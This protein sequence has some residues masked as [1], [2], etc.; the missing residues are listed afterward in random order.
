M[1]QDIGKFLLTLVVWVIC[2][3]VAVFPMFNE[4]IS[5]GAVMVIVIALIA[6]V[7]ATSVLWGDGDETDTD[8]K[9][10]QE[11]RK[12]DE[13]MPQVDLLLSMMDEDERAAFKDELKRRVLD[14]RTARLS[15]DGEVQSLDALLD[16]K[17]HTRA[18]E[19]S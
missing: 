5:S 16:E 8:I 18:E 17:H 11:K 10:A 7:G 2:G 19:R 12:R 9:T 14:E 4:G 13:T 1:F 6:A 15:D 3:F